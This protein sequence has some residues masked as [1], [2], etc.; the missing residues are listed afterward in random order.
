MPA[1]DLH[2]A[3]GLGNDQNRR[4]GS[5][6]RTKQLNP[7]FHRNSFPKN[8][9]EGAECIEKSARAI[10]SQTLVIAA[11]KRPSSSRRTGS[12]GEQPSH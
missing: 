1:A 9:K 10:E 11:A 2:L 5:V 4:L 8:A 12:A 6:S 3:S 7:L